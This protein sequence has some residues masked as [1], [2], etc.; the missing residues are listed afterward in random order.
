MALLH[1]NC[2]SKTL[3]MSVSFDAI[4]PEES[5]GIGVEGG[6]QAGAHP[7]LYLLHGASDDHTIW[8]RRTSIERYVAPLGLAVIMPS[9]ALSFYSNMAHGFR[10]FDYVADELPR[11]CRGFFHLSDRREDTH[12]AGLSMG[13]YGALKIGL[14]YPDRFATAGCFSAGNFLAGPEPVRDRPRDSRG[15]L[16]DVAD[17]VFGLPGGSLFD[18]PS[19]VGTEHDL[20]H[21]ARTAVASGRPMPRIFHVCGTEDFLV[22]NACRTRDYF[23]SLDGGPEYEYHEAPGAHTWEFWDEWVRSYLAFALPGAGR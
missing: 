1:V 2:F 10:Y 14:T 8:Q 22:E 23:D 12:V 16:N 3:G 15:P 9:V 20:F 4:L 6:D 11:I 17:T 7:V 21:L 5:Q 18:M 13:G 19:L